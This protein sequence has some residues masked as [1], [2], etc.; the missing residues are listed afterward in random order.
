MLLSSVTTQMTWNRTNRRLTRYVGTRTVTAL[1][2]GRHITPVG[3]DGLNQQRAGTCLPL[4]LDREAVERL[5][6]W[7]PGTPGCL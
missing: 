4:Q 1:K 7:E 3:E 2:L 6:W 5:G